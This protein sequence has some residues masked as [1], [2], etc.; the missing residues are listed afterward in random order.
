MFKRVL[1]ATDFSRHADRMLECIGEIPGMEEIV[2]VHVTTPGTT[3]GTPKEK[4]PALL[5][6]KKQVLEPLGIPVKTVIEESTNGDVVQGILAVATRER[7]SLI[8]MGARGRGFLR[9]LFLGSSSRG[10]LEQSTTNVLI[11]HFRGED[12]PN[13]EQFEKYCRNLFSKI[14]C[15]VDFSKPTVDILA[16]LQTLPFV[17]H[18]LLLNVVKN[19]KA[20]QDAVMQE[21]SQ[22]LDALKASLNKPE[23]KVRCIVRTGDP[24]QEIITTAN[25]EDVSL[26]LMPRYGLQDYAKSILLGRVAAGVAGKAQ[27]PIFMRYPVIH[28]NVESRELDPAEFPLAK[29]VWLGYHQQEA[30]PAI[31]RVFGVFVEG[32]LAAVARCRRHPDGLEVDGVF[33]PDEYRNRG[34]AKKA[35]AALVGACGGETLYMHSTLELVRFYGSFGFVAIPERE[36]PKTIRDRFNFAEGELKGAN[37]CPMRR[38]PTGAGS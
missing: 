8:I 19:G 6:E 14:L 9:N 12:V 5:N 2:L 1:V 24:V 38:I 13:E 31:D 34:Y 4:I 17:G 35:V 37:V 18:V 27:R 28:L 36:L 32:D 16:F 10:V 21:A 25:N 30:D 26:I 33:V 20:Q 7:V 29:K 23:G 3:N 11:M 15:P 22:K